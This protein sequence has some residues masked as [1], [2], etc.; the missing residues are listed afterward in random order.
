MGKKQGKTTKPANAYK[1]LY[2][3]EASDKTELSF[4]VGDVVE[5]LEEAD[6]GWVSA[7]SSDGLEG[8]VP[9][10]YFKEIALPQSEPE[11][12][13]AEESEPEQEP[14][15]ESESQEEEAEPEPE[16]EPEPESEPEP[17][18]EPEPDAASKKYKAQY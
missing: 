11:D 1:A 10:N 15:S 6:G 17:E 3:Y 4:A 7:K 2:D 18:P 9:S 14:E 5:F 13:E 8:Q 12:D 16:P